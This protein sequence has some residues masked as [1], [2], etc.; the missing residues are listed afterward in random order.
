MK[1]LD[2]I[3]PHNEDAE[4]SIL[5]AMM[6]SKDVIADVSMI[7]RGQDFY[8]PKNQNIFETIVELYS[9]N[10]PADVVMVASALEKKGILNTIGGANYL[11][12]LIAM[13]PSTSNVTYYA[14]IVKEKSQL[15]ALVQA[16]TRIT[17]LG[18]AEDGGDVEEI[19]NQAQ[20]ELYAA[21]DH[22]QDDGYAPIGKSVSKFQEYLDDLKHGKIVQDG[23]KTGLTDLDRLT[24]GLKPGQ[25]IIVAAR[26]AMGKSTLALDFCRYASV[27]SKLTS[28]VFS[29]EMDRMD[30]SRRILSAE[31]GVSMGLMK[32]RDPELSDIT[33]QKI[34]KATV[35]LNDAPLFIDD[36]PNITMTEIRTK[37]RRLKQQHDLKLVVVDYL[38]LMTSGKKVESRQQEVSEFSRQ[39]KLLAKELEV[40]VVAAAQLNRGP[41]QRDDHRP[42][43]SDLRESGSLEQ[44][45]DIV[46]LLSRQEVYEE[47]D[48]NGQKPHQGEADLYVAKHRN[49]STATIKLSFMG[50]TSKFGNLAKEKEP[51]Y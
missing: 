29:L 21:T 38:Q 45:A 25:L 2:R 13:V 28:V 34:A 6:L 51:E 12:E 33:W 17:Q 37:C 44:D 8:Q 14:D 26:P 27:H 15:R 48:E 39:L 1:N 10:G 50:A 31:S 40:P 5:G 46:M 49:G 4:K 3:Q 9:N 16:G 20:Q 23:V 11:H 35:K 19:I 47:A 18:Y 43:L 7:I 22:R 32:D 42:M 36:S 30:I 24:G 41:E